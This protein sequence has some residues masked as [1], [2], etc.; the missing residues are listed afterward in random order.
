MLREN[1]RQT[2]DEAVLEF[3]AIGNVGGL[4]VLGETRSGK[5]LLRQ[6][7]GRDFRFADPFRDFGERLNQKRPIRFRESDRPRQ[8]DS[9]DGGRRTRRNGGWRANERLGA[10]RLLSRCNG[11]I[12][13]GATNIVGDDFI[14]R[15]PPLQR[16]ARGKGA[17]ATPAGRAPGG[18]IERAHR[19][20]WIVVLQDARTC[21]VDG[22]DII[23][24][25]REVD[26]ERL[27]QR[28]LHLLIGPVEWLRVDERR[29]TSSRTLA[30]RRRT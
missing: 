21:G 8:H 16:R 17:A 15:A 29:S 14:R 26:V 12:A 27:V 13:A 23:A 18:R 11:G 28:L 4:P 25:I 19:P 9:T 30:G 1:R 24:E 22:N 20:C 7:R 3:V 6:R 2:L 5:D 10:A